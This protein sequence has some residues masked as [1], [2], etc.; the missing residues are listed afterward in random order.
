MTIVKIN[1][2]LN[3]IKHFYLIRKVV[4]FK[5][6]QSNTNNCMVASNYFNLIITCLDS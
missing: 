5:V 6:F 2:K 1:F 4:W 3:D